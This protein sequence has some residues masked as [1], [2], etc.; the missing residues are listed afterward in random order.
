MAESWYSGRVMADGKGSGRISRRV[1]S[2]GHFSIIDISN[3]KV[4]FRLISPHPFRS[5]T[6]VAAQ[7]CVDL[8]EGRLLLLG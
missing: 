2:G 5:K 3:S 8:V 7:G 6:D 4:K 1:E